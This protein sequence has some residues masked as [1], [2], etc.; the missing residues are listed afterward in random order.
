MLI[1]EVLLVFEDWVEISHASAGQKPDAIDHAGHAADSEGS[2]TEANENDFI[3][4]CVVGSNETVDFAYI[5]RHS[6][7]SLTADW[8]GDEPRKYQ[9]PEDLLWSYPPYLSLFQLPS[10]KRWFGERRPVQFFWELDWFWWHLKEPGEHR[11]VDTGSKLVS[12]IRRRWV[13]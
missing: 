1:L 6:Q 12:W 9:F 2:S 4:R 8:L 3:S 7:Y 5:L 11:L 10:G 13:S